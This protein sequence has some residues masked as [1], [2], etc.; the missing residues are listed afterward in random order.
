M[1]S[2]LVNRPV[3]NDEQ[4]TEASD[5]TPV[6]SGY[7]RKVEADTAGQ[8]IVDAGYDWEVEKRQVRYADPVS[9]ET[10]D[11]PGKF[12]VCRTDNG[13]ALGVVGRQY[14]CVQNR[15][16]F[17][18]ADGLVAAGQIK[19]DRVLG[20][21]A[22]VGI[23]ASLGDGFKVAGDEHARYL[24]IRTTHDG[25]GSVRIVPINMRLVCSNQFAV[26]MARK[27]SAKLSLRHSRSVHQRLKDAQEALLV[28]EG[29]FD[30][31]RQRAEMLATVKL[32]DDRFLEYVNAL[33]PLPEKE[34]G[35]GFTLATDRRAQ[36]FH[37]FYDDAR[38][39]QSSHP[40]SLLAAFNSVTQMVDHYLPRNKTPEQRFKQA[41]DG[42]GQ[43]LKATAW[44]TANEMAVHN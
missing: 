13:E 8:A 1:F 43:R 12:V 38:Q 10:R 6:W 41:T 21:R 19:I 36:V 24:L 34:E 27:S 25:S 35:R 22:S 40:M 15:D 31:Y 14:E 11:M 20:D 44:A 17:G 4:Q 2:D 7:G 32:T 23:V 28:A 37:N 3:R 26:A 9:G 33:V 30:D 5:L 18:F 16:V 39:T 29:A 42:G